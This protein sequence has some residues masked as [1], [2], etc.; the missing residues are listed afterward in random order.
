MAYT[1]NTQLKSV[2]SNFAKLTGVKITRDKIESDIEVNPYYPSLLSLSDTFSKFNIR[3]NAYKIQT[4]EFEQFDIATPFV[5]FVKFPET[6]EDFIVV[7]KLTES[8]VNY[9]YRGQKEESISMGAFLN[10]DYSNGT[11]KVF[12]KEVVWIAEPDEQS[13][14]AEYK[15]ALKKEQAGQSKKT[16][17]AAALLFLVALFVSFNVNGNVPLVPFLSVAMLKIV[18]LSVAAVLLMYEIDKNNAFVKQICSLSKKTNCEAVLSSK[19]AKI[20]GISWAEIGFFYFG[21]TTIGLLM[22]NLSFEAKVGWVAVVNALAVPYIFYSI[23]FQWKVV[24]Q[25]CPLCL[26]IQLILGLELIWSLAVYWRDPIALNVEL[27]T[28][29][30]ILFSVMLPVAGWYLLQPKLKQMN[31]HDLYMNAYKRLQ[32]HPEVFKHLLRLENKAPEGWEDIGINLGNPDGKHVVIKVCNPFCGPCHKTHPVLKELLRVNPDVRLKIIYINRKDE[33][34]IANKTIGHLLTIAKNNPSEIQQAMNDWYTN[35]SRDYEAFA[36]KHPLT[37]DTRLQS[38]EIVKMSSWCDRAL[39]TH[40]PTFFVN[41]Y[42]LPENYNI[43]ELK[44][45]L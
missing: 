11:P 24:K 8:T 12:Y 28:L 45:L 22:P 30:V 25:W 2:A 34:D 43:S 17:L 10:R 15:T 20:A 7:T 19:S 23:Y 27:P 42:R 16:I 26:A 18:G 4:D 33:A 44:N 32:Y 36:A 31:D 9:I 21:A 40:T 29:L 41:G 5:A 6:G 37:I 3:N 13:G 1:F 35:E 39:V 14:D 38:E